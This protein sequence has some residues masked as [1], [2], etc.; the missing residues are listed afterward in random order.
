MVIIVEQSRELTDLNEMFVK[1]EAGL[2]SSIENSIYYP[3]IRHLLMSEII[4]FTKEK[5]EMRRDLEFLRMNVGMVLSEA[6]I[7]DYLDG[8]KQKY[9]TKDNDMGIEYHIEGTRFDYGVAVFAIIKRDMVY[10]KKLVFRFRKPDTSVSVVGVSPTGVPIDESA[11][12]RK[13]RYLK[14]MGKK[15]GDKI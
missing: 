4:R 9:N 15:E 10:V 7:R 6:D 3:K 14:L 12:S 1:V 8:I 2:P 13:S 5:T 11:D